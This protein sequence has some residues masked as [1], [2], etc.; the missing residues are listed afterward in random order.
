MSNRNIYLV[1]ISTLVIAATVTI[2]MFALKDQ[3][4]NT[5]A[6]ANIL[7]NSSTNSV[8]QKNTNQPRTTVR[9]TKNELYIL[10]NGKIELLAGGVLK[11]ITEQQYDRLFGLSRR[12]TIWAGAER[13][14][15][16]AS[17]GM[18]P[19]MDMVLYEIQPSD[20]QV[21]QSKQLVDVEQTIFDKE[22]FRFVV[23]HAQKNV[24]PDLQS[25]DTPITILDD[26]GGVIE[27]WEEPNIHNVGVV[28]SGPILFSRSGTETTRRYLAILPDGKKEYREYEVDIG[29]DLT[30]FGDTALEVREASDRGYIVID[31][32]T[33]QPYISGSVTMAS[34]MRVLHGK[35]F[36]RGIQGDSWPYP[37]L[38]SIDEAGALT[39]V[40]GNNTFVLEGVNNTLV[41]AEPIDAQY[42]VR[43]W[44]TNANGQNAVLLTEDYELP[45]HS[46]PVVA[47]K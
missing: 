42:H 34:G 12:G 3:N 41:Y 17:E 25:W 23:L 32:V 14:S 20:G 30:F 18:P 46:F 36:F 10:N 26:S 29:V 22:N 19:A 24:T 13:P 2:M 45:W 27:S 21:L 6:N 47:N 33:K 37:Q 38:Y 8:S 7:S 11:V 5:E 15:S 16:V 43:I 28:N 9:E 44:E 31:H 40:L 35:T 4:A 1:I 39:H